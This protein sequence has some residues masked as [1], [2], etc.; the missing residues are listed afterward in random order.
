MSY[1][2][3]GPPV[4]NTYADVNKLLMRKGGFD[5]CHLSCMTALCISPYIVTILSNHTELWEGLKGEIEVA[6]LGGEE[7]LKSIYL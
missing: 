6:L 7:S 3:Y 5:Y 1:A 2:T 4:N